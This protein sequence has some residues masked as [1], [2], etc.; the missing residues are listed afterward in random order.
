MGISDHRLTWAGIKRKSALGTYQLIKRSVA[1]RLQCD[2]PRLVSKYTQIIEM[3]LNEAD[4]CRGI[5]QLEEDTTLR[6]KIIRTV[7][8]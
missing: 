5:M 3:M 1:R 2:A 8:I 4:I 6:S 7:R